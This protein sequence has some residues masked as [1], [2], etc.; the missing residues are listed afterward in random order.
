[1]T[2]ALLQTDLSD[3]PVRRGQVRDIYNLGDQLLQVSTDRISVFDWVLPTGIP[4]KGRV[5]TNLSAFWFDKLDTPSH[6]LSMNLSDLPVSESQREMLDG[7]S[8]LT[9][10]RSER[11]A[12]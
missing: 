12:H 2:E 4:D 11:R 9:G 3:Y 10:S 5:L 8:I 1:M 7:R 6:F